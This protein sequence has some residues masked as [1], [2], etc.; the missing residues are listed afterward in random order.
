MKTIMITGAGSGLGKGTAIGLAK[1]GHKI[2]AG[3]HVWEQKS[4]LLEEIKA[5]KLED[6]I[7][8]IKLDILN[9][10]DCINASE[11]EIDILVNN[12]GMGHSGPVGEMPVDL[13]REV[14]ETNVFSTLEFSS[15]QV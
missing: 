11:H 8:V 5:L 3:V 9:D 2:I 15:L 14:M 1:K 4:Q 7:T 13:L 6:N 12:A 10:L